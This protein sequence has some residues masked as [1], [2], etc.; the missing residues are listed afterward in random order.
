M[1]KLKFC[2]S[3]WAETSKHYWYFLRVEDKV[4]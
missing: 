3:V 2:Y 1:L 4:S